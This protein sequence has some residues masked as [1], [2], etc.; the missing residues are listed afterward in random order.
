MSSSTK[1][2]GSFTS[3]ADAEGG[4]QAARVVTLRDRE[5][6]VLR[7]LGP[8]DEPLLRE[9]F[10][11]AS[12][13]DIHFRCFG[14]MRGFAEDMAHRLAHLD[15]KQEFALAVLTPP[16]AGREE[17]LGVVHLEKNPE[18]E[19]T[20]EFDIMVRADLKQ[21]GLGY[22]LMTEVLRSAR[23]RGLEAVTGMILRDNY[24]MLQMAHELGFATE[25]VEDDLV[26]VKAPLARSP[27]F[28]DAELDDA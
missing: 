16:E 18:A 25:S 23:R 17:I 19:T 14:A 8:D 27:V 6:Y 26:K 3:Q 15:P 24:V 1:T 12:Q 5:H 11:R 4:R 10:A 20:A 28:D 7:E 22:L 2:A 21:H 9:M 13:E